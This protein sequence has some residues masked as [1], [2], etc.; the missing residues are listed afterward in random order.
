MRQGRF[1][2]FGFGFSEFGFRE[3][4]KTPCLAFFDVREKTAVEIYFPALLELSS[5]FAVLDSD[6]FESTV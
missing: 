5:T 2:P 6:D 3:L 1:H 4:F